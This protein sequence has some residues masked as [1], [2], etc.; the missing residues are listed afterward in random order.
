MTTNAKYNITQL[1]IAN[2]ANVNLS[3]E[4]KQK[5]KEKETEFTGI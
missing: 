1:T 2:N 5:F 3:R 4:K